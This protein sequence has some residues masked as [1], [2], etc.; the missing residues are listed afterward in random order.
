MKCPFCGSE[1]VQYV[2]HT[3]Q[4]NFGGFQACCGYLLMGPLG[5]LCGLCGQSESTN[6]YWVCHDCGNTFPTF[7]GTW[8]MQ[9][10]ARIADRQKQ[11]EELLQRER[12][13]YA[14]NKAYL[15]PLLDEDGTY[16]VALAA[17][18]KAVDEHAFYQKK[19]QDVL[20]KL[21]N[22]PERNVRQV[23][24]KQLG[25]LNVLPFFLYPAIII[26]GLLRLSEYIDGVLL[27]ILGILGLI[28]TI[29]KDS[30]SIIFLCYRFPAYQRLI[31]TI[32]EL[33]EKIKRMEFTIDEIKQVEQ[34]EKKYP[35]EIPTP[36]P[37]V[38][39][40]SDLSQTDDD[41]FRQWLSSEGG[42]EF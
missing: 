21:R 7:M 8:N 12:E 36:E 23:A 40:G 25:T 27:I 1:H 41:W 19:R 26:V 30:N 5:L 16:S 42:S 37:V 20:R 14:R 3:T 9:R 2:A 13:Q 39:E 32:E 18:Q 10:E 6:E 31:R 15:A 24:K 4:T 33:S 34:Y 28:I 38:P 35:H 17:Y 22:H 11:Q 29:R